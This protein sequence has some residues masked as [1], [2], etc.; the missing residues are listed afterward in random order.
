MANVI[1]ENITKKFDDVS[2]VDDFSLEV[3][4][5]VE[6]SKDNDTSLFEDDIERL[7]FKK[8]KLIEQNRKCHNYMIHTWGVNHNE[9]LPSLFTSSGAP[10]IYK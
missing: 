9:I 7:G 2:A 8:C 4:D 1:F 3:K 10:I 5:N 6:P